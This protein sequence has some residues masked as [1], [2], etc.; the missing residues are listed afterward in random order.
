VTDPIIAAARFLT[1]QLSWLRHATHPNGEPYA[2]EVFREIGDCAARMRSLVDGPREQRF[3][4]PCTATL[5]TLCGIVGSAHVCE[6]DIPV[7][8]CDGD[9]YGVAGAQTGRCR[10]C[11]ATVDQAERRQWLDDEVRARAFTAKDIAD[12]YGINVKTIRSW[13]TERQARWDHSGTLVQPSR[14][15]KLH[16]HGLDRDGR[17][18][19]LVGDVLDLAAD[20]AARRE[21]RR[22]ERARKMEQRS[23]GA[24]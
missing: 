22:V 5:C 12:A 8:T 10:T 7:W 14:A 13:A 3:L 17:A 23:G 6:G 4:G 18:L 16:T 1:A 19:F 11:G 21:E 24:A 9:V 2:T 15:A 20:D